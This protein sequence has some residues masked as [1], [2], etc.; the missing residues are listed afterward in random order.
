MSAPFFPSGSHG[1]NAMHQ[2]MRRKQMRMLGW[3]AAGGVLLGV[4]AF[5]AGLPWYGALGVT[6]F[7]AVTGG[8]VLA[9]RS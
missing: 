5:A 9:E 8:V 1:P 4:V 3:I 2:A 7:V 6:A